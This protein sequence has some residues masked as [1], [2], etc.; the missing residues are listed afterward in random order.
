MRKRKHIEIRRGDIWEFQSNNG[1]ISRHVRSIAC[2][3]VSYIRGDGKFEQC[4]LATFKKWARFGSLSSADD[5]ANRDEFGVVTPTTKSLKASYAEEKAREA[6]EAKARLD[7]PKIEAAFL[8]GSLPIGKYYLGRG[9]TVRVNHQKRS[10]SLHG[11]V[12]REGGP[13]I[14]YANGDREWRKNGHLHREDGPAVEFSDGTRHWW[15]DGE[16]HRADGP[17]VE[18]ADGT[19]EWWLNGEKVKKFTK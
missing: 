4:S 10:W 1:I 9:I 15:R 2:E 17:A 6:R 14:E 18:R 3:V 19:Q 11:M 8:L 12:H 7:A 16:R 13:A 5:W